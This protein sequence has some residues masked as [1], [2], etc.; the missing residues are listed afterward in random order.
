MSLVTAVENPDDLNNLGVPV[1]TIDSKGTKKTKKTTYSR[2]YRSEDDVGNLSKEALYRARMKYGIYNS[3]AKTKT[4][5]LPENITTND[6]VFYLSKNDEPYS[7]VKKGKAENYDAAMKA[8][9]KAG[10]M[11]QID[12]KNINKRMSISSLGSDSSSMKSDGATLYQHRRG[13]S[14]ISSKTLVY[15][16]NQEESGTTNQNMMKGMDLSKVLAG[17]EKRA[18]QRIKSR[19]QPAKKFEIYRTKKGED[20]AYKINTRSIDCETM[21]NIIEKRKKESVYNKLEQEELEHNAKRDDIQHKYA[22]GAANAVISMNPE[23]VGEPDDR[24]RKIETLEFA[25]AMNSK[26]V[27]DLAY[28]KASKRLSEIDVSNDY[29]RIYGN[30]AYNR[31]AVSK[32]LEHYHQGQ[33]EAANN[34]NKVALGG[35]LLLPREQVDEIARGLVNPVLGE[36]DERAQEQREMQTKISRRRAKFIEAQEKYEHINSVKEINNAKLLAATKDKIAKNKKA[37]RKYHKRRYS[38]LVSKYDALV[39]TKMQQLSEC[40]TNNKDVYINCKRA[41]QTHQINKVNEWNNWVRVRHCPIQNASKLFS[42]IRKPYDLAIEKANIEKSKAVADLES[43]EEKRISLE[44]TLAEKKKELEL[45]KKKLSYQ[46]ESSSKDVEFIKDGTDEDDTVDTEEL[47][48]KAKISKL[49]AQILTEEIMLQQFRANENIL[50]RNC[51]LLENV[52]DQR[53]MKLWLLESASQEREGRESGLINKLNADPIPKDRLVR[54]SQFH[55]KKG[56]E[57]SKH[58]GKSDIQRSYGTPTTDKHAYQSNLASNKEKLNNRATNVA[59]TKMVSRGDKA[60]DDVALWRKVFGIGTEIPRNRSAIHRSQNIARKTP[61]RNEVAMWRKILG[62]GT[63]MPVAQLQKNSIKMR[64]SKPTKKDVAVWRKVLGFGSELPENQGYS[65][66]ERQSQAPFAQSSPRDDVEPWQRVLGINTHA[67][68]V[69][70]PPRKNANDYEISQW[71]KAL[72]IGTDMPFE[73]QKKMYPKVRYTEPFAGSVPRDD[74][75]TIRKLAGLNTETPKMVRTSNNVKAQHKVARWRVV[76]GMGSNMPENFLKEFQSDSGYLDSSYR[77]KSKYN[78]G[79]DIIKTGKVELYGVSNVDEYGNQVPCM[80]PER[81]ITLCNYP[82]GKPEWDGSLARGIYYFP[83]LVNTSAFQIYGKISQPSPHEQAT[84]PGTGANDVAAEVESNRTS[85]HNFNTLAP[86]NKQAVMIPNQDTE[87]RVHNDGNKNKKVK[88]PR[89]NVSTSNNDS[90]VGIQPPL[91]KHSKKVIRTREPLDNQSRNIEVA[92][93]RR[94]F[95]VGT[96]LPRG[97]GE[98][99]LTKLTKT[100]GPMSSSSGGMLNK[101]VA[102]RGIEGS[103]FDGQE[104]GKKTQEQA[105]AGKINKSQKKYSTGNKIHNNKVEANEKA[106]GNGS[107]TTLTRRI[108]SPTLVN[109]PTAVKNLKIKGPDGKVRRVNKDETS[110]SFE[111]F[112]EP[113]STDASETHRENEVNNKTQSSGK[114]GFFKELL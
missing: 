98:V 56:N 109:Q 21:L 114:K 17:A 107:K 67:P 64:P 81:C 50:R 74:V 70:T 12:T 43:I 68:K 92:L 99:V 63:N 22:L 29:D 66:K 104:V 16:E 27:M 78:P 10:L 49:N 19:T 65:Q 100:T 31:A 73:V 77:A 87:N 2:Y 51:E 101:S 25:R 55:I 38:K 83:P 80:E 46:S 44:E 41:L 103:S 91:I 40:E 47:I 7:S 61:A 33:K 105:S 39:Y 6:V 60:D 42:D 96:N 35:G 52:V 86:R 59:S 54:F 4:S 94:I 57:V 8:A 90:S 106:G 76:L 89:E 23:V 58:N 34:R 36:I 11:E 102:G 97:N 69:I 82:A 85:G 20:S 13:Y 108:S 30:E 48:M 53:E 1:V 93:W 28:S 45:L 84:L 79:D 37:I 95:G 110:P 24:Y 113:P 71:R 32:A 5:G 3:P 18:N 72:G 9:A 14:S 75:T 62:V 88:K 26:N 111:G 112:S 15:D